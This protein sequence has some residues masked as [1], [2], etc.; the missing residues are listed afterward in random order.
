MPDFNEDSF[1]KMAK[2]TEEFSYVSKLPPGT[3]PSELQV[4]FNEYKV[5]LP[6]LMSDDFI[7]ALAGFFGRPAHWSIVEQ[8]LRDQRIAPENVR[9]LRQAVVD[10]IANGKQRIVETVEYANDLQRNKPEPMQ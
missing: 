2:E 10:H 5:G 9:M 1:E 8:Y 4:F 6:V 7:A 3:H